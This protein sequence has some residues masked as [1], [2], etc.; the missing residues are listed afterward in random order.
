MAAVMS[1]RIC[2]GLELNP[3]YVDVIINRWQGFTG[4]VATNQDGDTLE[5]LAVKRKIAA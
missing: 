2:V 5:T 3:A 1:G 4:E